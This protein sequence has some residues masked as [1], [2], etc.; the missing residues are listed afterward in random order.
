MKT[1]KLIF[2]V[3]LGIILVL[4]LFAQTDFTVP[5]QASQDPQLTAAQ[6]D[7][8]TKTALQDFKQVG[9]DSATKKLQSETI[10]DTDKSKLAKLALPFIQNIG[11]VNSQVEYYAQTFAGTVFVTSHGLRYSFMQHDFKPNSNVGTRISGIAVDETFIG[12]YGT[13]NPRGIDKSSSQVSYFVGNKDSWKSNAPTYNTLSLGSVWPQVDITL[14]AYGKSTEKIFT[15]HPGGNVNSIRVALDGINSISVDKEGKLL[16]GTQL[17]TVSMTRPVAYQ[18]INGMRHGIE[19]SYVVSGNSYGFTVGNYDK[20]FPLIIDPLLASKTLGSGYDTDMARDRSGNV[21]ITGFTGAPNYPT[22]PGAYQTTFDSTCNSCYPD[23]Q[24]NVSNYFVSK[25]DPS[26]STLLASTF[27]GTTEDDWSPV[28]IALD[29]SGNV[30]ITGVNPANYPY[31]SNAYQ[32][33]RGLSF[34]SKLNPSL[35]SLLASTFIDSFSSNAIA[36]DSS[37]NVYVVGTGVKKFDPS[38]SSLLA[39]TSIGGG[40]AIALDSSGNIYTTG[41]GVGVYKYNSTLSLLASASPGAGTA[42]AIALDSTGNVYITGY[43]W[44]SNYPTTTG[45]YQRTFRGSDFGNQGDAFVTEF[46]SSLSTLLAST[47]IGGSSNDDPYGIALD[48]SG[49]VYITGLTLSSNYPTTACAYKSTYAFANGGIFISK[50]DPSLSSLLASTY[51]TDGTGYA[52]ALDSS[53]DVYIGGSFTVS[54]FEITD[55]L[56]GTASCNSPSTPQPPTGLTAT[57]VSSSQINLSWTAPSNNGGSAITG[58]KIEKSTDGGTTWSTIVSNTGSTSTTYS[59]T[60]LAASTT[61]A[62]RVS[63]I[64][65]VGTSA[66]SNTASATTNSAATI[67]NSDTDQTTPLVIN[68]GDVLQINSGATLTMDSSLD[69]NGTIY[70]LSGGSLK[71]DPGFTMTN[72]VAGQINNT[73]LIITPPSDTGRSTITN[74]GKLNNMNTIQ[75]QSTSSFTNSNGAEINNYQGASLTGEGAHLFNAGKLN[76]MGSLGLYAGGLTNSGEFDNTGSCSNCAITNTATGIVNNNGQLSGECCIDNSGVVNNEGFIKMVDVIT[77]RSGG[78]LNNDNGTIVAFGNDAVIDNHGVINNNQGTINDTL[79]AYFSN[80]GGLMSNSGII[81]NINGSQTTIFDNTNG[82]FRNNCGG[83]F[84]NEG[85]FKG[86]PIINSCSPLRSTSSSVIPNPATGTVGVPKNFKASVYDSNVGTKTAPT[87]TI[88]WSDN[89]AGG[90]FGSSTCTLATAT[91]DISQCIVS[92]TPKTGQV[93]T[94]G[95]VIFQDDYS[96]NAGWT[97]IGTS[98]TVNSP[99]FPG[100]V[101]YNDEI[102]GSGVDQNRVYKQLSTTLP[103]HEWI[104]YFD[105]E[106]T[107]SSL[108]RSYIFDLTATSDDPFSQSPSNMIS[109]EHGVDVDKLFVQRGIGGALSAGIPIV[110]NTQYYVKL[111]RVQTQLILSVF[112][113]PARTIN[114]AGS[115]VTL[116]IAATDYNNNLNFIQHDGCTECGPGRTLTAEIDNTLITAG[117]GPTTITAT[118]S[119]DTT[120][121][122]SSGTS[123]LTVNLRTTTTTIIPNP[124]N[125]TVGVAKNFKASVYDSNTGTKTAPTGTVSW[126]DN[127]AG[128]TFGSST[129]TLAT[130]TPD[131]SQCIISYTPLKTGPVTITATYQGD[132]T[133]GTSSG[134]SALTVYLHITRTT[135]KTAET[136]PANGT[137]GKPKPF[138]VIVTDTSGSGRTAPTG[139]VSWSDNGAGGTFSGTTCTLGPTGGGDSSTCIVSYTPL[140]IGSVTITATYPGDGTHGTSSGSSA[141]TVSTDT[142]T[143]TVTPKPATT[144]NSKDSVTFHVT[145]VDSSPGPQSIPTGLVIWKSSDLS[146]PFGPDSCTLTSVAGSTNTSTCDIVYF[147]GALDTCVEFSDSITGTYRGDSTHARSSDTTTLSVTCP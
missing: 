87:G 126:G 56:S 97:Q 24:R 142:T 96:S 112:S 4:S 81:N 105:Y 80:N 129:C 71:I 29:S 48:S 132:G 136:N 15:I 117:T 25:L 40:N 70:I 60:G 55:D 139:T 2:S 14:K 47:F 100:V 113:D 45:A 116:D 95:N 31:T 65:S 6:F 42:T 26:L 82:T 35:S 36:L 21:Y 123:T 3:T 66:P 121:S 111:E 89:G 76:N 93:S 78:I 67:I 135:V 61:Y 46:D 104:A 44:A 144:S 88:S 103:S 109:V 23:S 140:K 85:V 107:A 27:I 131:I 38:L 122:T 86:N 127:G 52:I 99:S 141:L 22:T 12:S 28:A 58:Y 128:G 59:D 143:T 16:I 84:N 43:T 90:T 20:H 57:T 62:Y 41:G 94:S 18:E 110:S 137:A 124:A 75:M 33:A 92:Y 74:D 72:H 68:Q 50:F 5:V 69:N 30:Y 8:T 64:N 54:V 53:R 119:G 39:S 10:S 49:N 115:P 130:A 1:L 133:H 51:L 13:I 134:S 11:Q 118:Y 125:G 32:T 34:V 9:T 108:A 101:K 19:V 37:G 79:G 145:V 17:G 77:V 73:G 114:V 7:T 83:V 102:G 138:T 63:A 146:V 106:Y 147:Y 91:P 98:V 120:H